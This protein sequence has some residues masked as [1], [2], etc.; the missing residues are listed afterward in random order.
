MRADIHNGSKQ[1]LHLEAGCIS[2]KTNLVISES[3]ATHGRSIHL[4][5]KL[6]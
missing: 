1:K 2:S 6:S 4:G 5:Q 3:L